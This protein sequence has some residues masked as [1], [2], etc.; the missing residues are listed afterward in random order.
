MT[1]TIEHLKDIAEEA[2]ILADTL[3]DFK[4]E[5]VPEELAHL[6]TRENLL[7]QAATNLKII[8]MFEEIIKDAEQAS[9]ALPD[10]VVVG[11][12]VDDVNAEPE[13]A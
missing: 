12:L 10:D 8:S 11:E 5:A 4:L 9:P 6:F 13:D 1:S 3:P 2:V 7:Q